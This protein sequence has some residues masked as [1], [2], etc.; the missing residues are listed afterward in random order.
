MSELV[1][2]QPVVGASGKSR[3]ALGIWLDALGELFVAMG[4]PELPGDTPMTVIDQILR[5]AAQRLRERGGAVAWQ[6]RK[7]GLDWGPPTTKKAVAD[8][9]VA[10]GYDVRAL[11]LGGDEAELA[12]ERAARREAQQELERYKGL[13][14]KSRQDLMRELQQQGWS[15]PQSAATVAANG[16]LARAYPDGLVLDPVDR[17]IVAECRRIVATTDARKEPQVKALCEWVMAKI[18]LRPPFTAVVPY[19]AG[20]GQAVNAGVDP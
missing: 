5:A 15:P 2:R 19:P 3:A 17:A 18:R 13:L 8:A 7:R 11:R 16:G 6:V 20:A 4:R 1:R 9:L 12:K 10:D 14:A